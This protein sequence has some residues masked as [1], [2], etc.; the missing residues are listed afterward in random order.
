MLLLTVE[1]DRLDPHKQD[2]VLFE[3]IEVLQAQWP[4]VFKELARFDAPND[5]R[6][7]I[8]HALLT[9]KNETIQAGEHW[10]AYTISKTYDHNCFWWHEPVE[11]WNMQFRLTDA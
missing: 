1:S 8:L 4:H 2:F 5:L 10:Y 7:A 9:H 6:D 11:R 3:D